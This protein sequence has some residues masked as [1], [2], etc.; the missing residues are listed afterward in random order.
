MNFK[1]YERTCINFLPC[2]AQSSINSTNICT[3]WYFVLVHSTEHFFHNLRCYNH[4]V[5]FKSA[6]PGYNR[7]RLAVAI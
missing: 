6:N 2:Q 3:D 4:F 7:S 5:S 1:E